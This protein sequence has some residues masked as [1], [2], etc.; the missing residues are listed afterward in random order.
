Q[1]PHVSI[2]DRVFVETTEGDLT[3]K[4]ENNTETGE[5]IYCEPVDDPDQTLDDAEFFYAILGS[6]IL[7]KIRPYQEEAFRYFVYCEKTRQVLRLDTIEHACVLLPDDHGVIFSN[8][9]FLQTGEYKIFDRRLSNMLFSQRIQAPN[10]ED[11]LYVFYNRAPG[12]HILLPYNLIAQ[13]VD[14]PITCSGFSL[15]ENGQL[16]YFKAQDE[17]QRHHALQIWQ[18]PYVGADVHPTEQVDSLLYK[19]GNR[20]VVRG[21]AECHE[22]LNLLAK[23]DTYANLFVDLAKKVGD[24][25]D[26]YYWIGNDEAMNLAED[27]A[28]IKQAAEAAISEFDKVVAMRRN[29]AEQLAKVVARTREITASIH[30]RRFEVIG[31]FVTSLADLRGVRGEIISLGELRYIDNDQVDALERDELDVPVDLVGLRA[32]LS[33]GQPVAPLAPGRR[34]PRVAKHLEC[35][36]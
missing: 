8:G 28:T 1:H 29:T 5:G 17:P 4:I 30:A 36:E 34:G 22:V 6:L 13:K 7:L 10:G 24:I 33:I 26:A 32:Q 35:L 9:Y 20:D 14:T 23:E 2:E 31:D 19:I 16:I 27:L 21:M 3:I 25:L 15:F 18:T 12:D 11:Y